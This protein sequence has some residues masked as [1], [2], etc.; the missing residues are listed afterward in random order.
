M[1]SKIEYKGVLGWES[2][3][4]C[5]GVPPEPNFSFLTYI[6]TDATVPYWASK[7]LEQPLEA[8]L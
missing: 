2:Q 1:T 7:L 6:L 8:T 3:T 5:R 4:R